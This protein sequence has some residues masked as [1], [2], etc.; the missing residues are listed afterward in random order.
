MIVVGSSLVSE[1][2]RDIRF[3]CDLNHC[4]GQCCVEGDGGAPLLD[5]EIRV[6]EENFSK[7]EPYIPAEHSDIIKKEGFYYKDSDQ[8]YCTNLVDDRQCVF[9][10]FEKN[11]SDGRLIAKCAMEKA[12]EKGE[13]SFQKP[14]SCH[15]YPIRV[16]NYGD[17]TAV[18]FHYW[19]EVCN[20]ALTQDGLP[21]YKMLKT[22]LIRYF[23]QE[24][25]EELV[26]QCEVSE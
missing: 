15:L 6:I 9:V 21:L 22:P 4:N 11:L 12:F 5:E 24:W 18:N 10:F 7:I 8:E 17:F 3:C 26:E 25:Y 20:K 14:V 23:G 16:T 13:I 2:I 19:Q 1:D